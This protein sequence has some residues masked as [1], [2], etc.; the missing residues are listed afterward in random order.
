M[1]GNPASSLPHARLF[2]LFHLRTLARLDELPVTW[3]ERGR[4]ERRF[5][6]AAGQLDSSQSELAW[7]QAQLHQQEATQTLTWQ[8]RTGGDALAPLTETQLVGRTRSRTL[9]FT[10]VSVLTVES[11]LVAHR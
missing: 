8:I 7:L 11:Q 10:H 5:N 4:A 6:A 3:E 2:L 1:A 9:S